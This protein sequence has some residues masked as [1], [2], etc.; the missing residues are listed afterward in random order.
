M[1]RWLASAQNREVDCELIRSSLFLKFSEYYYI[2]LNIIIIKFQRLKRPVDGDQ[3]LA[4]ISPFP[5]G[6]GH[7]PKWEII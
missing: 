6:M 7:D 4:K 3:E 1:A 5:V 2:I